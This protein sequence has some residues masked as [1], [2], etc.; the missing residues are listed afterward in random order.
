MDIFEMSLARYEM[1][2]EHLLYVIDVFRISFVCY[3]CV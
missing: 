1:S 2:Y 3:G